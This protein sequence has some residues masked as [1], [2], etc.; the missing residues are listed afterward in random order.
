MDF[1]GR[2]RVAGGARPASRKRYRAVFDE[3]V[4]HGRGKGLATWDRVT[5]RALTF[6]TP[7]DE[8]GFADGLLHSFRHFSCSL[9]ANRGLPQRV[10]MRRLGHTG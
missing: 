4:A 5:A 10:V 6:P 9:W 7:P 2:T 8:V 3:S 1:V